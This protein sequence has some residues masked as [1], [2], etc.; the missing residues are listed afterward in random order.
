MIRFVVLVLFATACLSVKI[1]MFGGGLT[2]DNN[3]A[4]KQIALDT[5]KVTRPGCDQN[6]DT[7]DCPRVAVITSGSVDSQSGIN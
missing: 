1:Y 5:G 4:W 7:T 6:W 3:E 2:Q